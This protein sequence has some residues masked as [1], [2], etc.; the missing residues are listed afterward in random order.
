MAAN[1]PVFW[2]VLCQRRTD[3]VPG[4]DQTACSNFCGHQKIGEQTLVLLA[5]NFQVSYAIVDI[6]A[7]YELRTGLTQG[8]QISII[9]CAKNSFPRFH[10]IFCQRGSF[11]TCL[12]PWSINITWPLARPRL[13]HF[14]NHVFDHQSSF[15]VIHEQWKANVVLH[16]HEELLRTCQSDIRLLMVGC[17]RFKRD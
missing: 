13:L 5:H 11:S 6:D 15:G 10:F 8:Q 7:L 12:I 9:F 17:L 2:C 4:M 16:F 3:F 14:P 1:C